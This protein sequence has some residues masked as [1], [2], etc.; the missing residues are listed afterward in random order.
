MIFC[1]AGGITA[2]SMTSTSGIIRWTNG[3]T[4]GREIIAYTI[5][6]KTLYTDDWKTVVENITAQVT[7][8][9]LLLGE[10]F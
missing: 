8:F 2:L 1:V 3:A 9:C 4:N 10:S 6:A 7:T 5:Q